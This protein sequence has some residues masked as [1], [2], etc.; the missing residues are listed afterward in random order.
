[1]G[2]RKI[3]RTQTSRGNPNEVHVLIRFDKASVQHPLRSLKQRI[4]FDFKPSVAEAVQ[5][6]IRQQP[7]ANT[8]GHWNPTPIVGILTHQPK[9]TL[10]TDLFH[11]DIP[12][13]Q[14]DG[15]FDL[16]TQHKCVPKRLTKCFERPERNEKL[17]P[18][19]RQGNT[20]FVHT[21]YFRQHY[22]KR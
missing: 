6:F 8:R 16:R 20:A 10:I 19:W 18:E 9:G 1:M 11:I 13:K 2:R 17:Y 22:R 21:Q 15:Y 7:S 4:C 3:E 14:C 12:V 5:L